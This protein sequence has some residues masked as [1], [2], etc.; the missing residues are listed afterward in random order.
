MVLCSPQF[1]I[2]FF[3]IAIRQHRT[4]INSSINEQHKQQ[5]QQ[6]QQQRTLL[7]RRRTYDC[8]LR[9][10]DKTTTINRRTC[11]KLIQF[12][13]MDYKFILWT[14]CERDFSLYH[15]NLSLILS[16]KIERNCL[17]EF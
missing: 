6:L 10:C 7:T 2:S 1:I 17:K 13:S 11:S 3:R 9:L 5:Q 4:K 12:S 15:S 14:I 16:V 8:V